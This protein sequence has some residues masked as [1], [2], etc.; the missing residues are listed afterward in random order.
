ML[1]K[2]DQERNSQTKV[3]KKSSLVIIKLPRWLFLWNYLWLLQFVA[4]QL[5]GLIPW[6]YLFKPEA[7]TILRH[8][9]SNFQMWLSISL[10]FIGTLQQWFS[11]WALAEYPVDLNLSDNPRLML[12]TW[13]LCIAEQLSV[14]VL[15]LVLVARGASLSVSGGIHL[16]VMLL[17]LA[18]HRLCCPLL[19]SA[20]LSVASSENCGSRRCWMRYLL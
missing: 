5:K 7:L 8:P 1:L 3:F 16:N 6:K 11:L 4:D 20:F 10:Y 13:R 18:P 19:P 9:R 2:K 17:W 15:I 12:S 14:A